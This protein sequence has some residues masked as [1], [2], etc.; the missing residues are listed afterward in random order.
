MIPLPH[1]GRLVDRQLAAGQVERLDEELSDLPQIV[2]DLDQAYD[3]VKI[4]T[5]AYSPL[6]GFMDR[7]TIESVLSTGRLPN[8]LP[9]PIPIFLAPS[10]AENARRIESLSPGDDVALVDGHGRFFALLHLR[11]KYR[12]DREAIARATYRTTDPHHPNVQALQAAGDVVLGGRIDLLRPVDLPLPHFEFTP[13]ATRRIFAQRGWS[14]VAAYQTR[15][16]PHTAHEYLQRLALE[17]DDVDALFIHPVVGPLKPGDYRPE[18]VL[19]SYQAFVGSYYPADRVLLGTLTIAMRYAGP[20][21]ALF[22]AIVRKNHGCSHYIVGRDQAGVG[23]YY[24]PYDCHRIFDE[25][26]VGIMPLRYREAF[27]CRRCRGMAS[28][29]TCRHGTVDRVPASQTAVRRS[30]QESRALPVEILRPE[31]ADVLGQSPRPLQGGGLVPFGEA[32]GES[33][34]GRNRRAGADAY[35]VS[36]QDR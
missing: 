34:D 8:A 32:P 15:N 10:G 24:D 31:V 35:H 14:G 19:A 11:E 3:A 20:K 12:L 36:A 28:E 33:S 9:W 18:V 16:V 1:G 22:L 23:R 27:Y 7:T 5:G 29:K 21:A 13:A 4:G 17:R 25:F 6:E 2:P 30:I 26:P